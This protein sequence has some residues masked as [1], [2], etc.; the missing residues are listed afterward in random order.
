MSQLDLLRPLSNGYELVGAVGVFRPDGSCVGE[1]VTVSE[2]AKMRGCSESR[3]RTL[4]SSKRVV[5]RL[6]G[7]RRVVSVISVLG[8]DR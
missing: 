1:W 4:I 2:G 6:D 8:L 7:R 5:S 3:L